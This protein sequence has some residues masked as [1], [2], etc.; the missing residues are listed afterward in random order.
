MNNETAVYESLKRMCIQ[1]FKDNGK[2][3]GVT[4]ENLSRSLNMQRTNVSR[5]LSKLVQAGKVRKNAARPVLYFVDKD[6][7]E[8]SKEADEKLSAFD[9]CIG[10]EGSLKNQIALAKAA[11]VYPPNGLHILILGET[12]VG[13][14]YFAKCIFKY[15]LQIGKVR[16]KGKFAVFNCAD[17]AN[18]PQLLISHLF[19]VK[20]GTY[21]G[22]TEDREGIIEKSRNGI[23]FLD[24]VHRLPPEGQEMLFTLM[25]EGKYVPFGGTKEIKID[26]MIISATTENIN[27][28]LLKTFTRRIPVTISLPPLREWSVNERIEL[29]ESFLNAESKR[30]SKKIKID[31]DAVTAIVNYRCPNNIGQLKSDIQIASAKAF[32]RSM[33]DNK[34]IKIKLE[35]F[36]NEVRNGLLI[37]KKIDPMELR[38]DIHGQN[39]NANEDLEDKYSISRNIYEFIDKRSEYL[40]R[41]GMDQEEIKNRLIND[42]EK[43]INDYIHNI[44]ED[45]TEDIKVIVNDELYNLLKSFMKLAEYKL[46]RNIPKNI[47]VGLLMHI[48]AFLT[49]I[50]ENRIIENPKIDEIK[51]KYPKEFK[52]AL[53]LAYKLEEKYNITIPIGE[54]GFITMFFAVD[55]KK[56]NSKVAIIVAMHGNSTASS[57]AEV[58][59]SL[60]NTNHVV[61]FD[62]PLY[63]K[64]EEAL[65]RIEELVKEKD[66]GKG[67]LILSDMGSLKYFGKIIKENTGIEVQ[68]I[69]MVSTAVVIEAA[70][71]A[72]LNDSLDEILKSVVI[73]SRYVGNS[74]EKSINKSR[75][76]II[77]ACF[78]G[79][80]TALK[81]KQLVYSKFNKNEYE[82]FNLSMK[83]KNEFKNTVLKMKNEYEIKYIISAFDPHVDDI[84]YIPM[85]IF[86]KEFSEEDIKDSA[87]DEQMINDMKD[88]YR[89]CLSLNNHDFIVNKFVSIINKMKDS[90]GL[91]L[92]REKLSGLLMHF[93]C[94]LEKLR[95]KEDICKCKSMK[96]ILSRYSDLFN[97]L[98]EGV[99]DIEKSLGVIIPDEGL[100]SIIEILVNI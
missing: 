64:P 37:S 2:V 43:F 8:F 75:K 74:L 25:D 15:T 69:D 9:V 29:I 45:D 36:S 63:M 14:S 94:L 71:K 68:T 73:E 85:E 13:K 54:I 31:E 97:M 44:R 60:L 83:D 35:D 47:F 33:F 99:V 86:F 39:S 5:E 89:D 46:N 32:L 50:K 72:M 7:V 42:V 77:T 19:G 95:D 38:L 10:K 92:D 34:D 23:L 70:R 41:K 59:N 4:T 53:L 26:V 30:V 48:D 24:E 62:M 55:G 82:V 67:T 61:G 93:G 91:H 28:V 58:S 87:S 49:R 51:K 52:I 12:G 27:S 3:K 76:V 80:G 57:M 40:K 1:Q 78:T 21:T 88:V 22:A 98:K 11:V 79:E 100:G 20:K 66:Q 56:V 6:N 17:Y 96:I 81:L 84:E 65:S 18:N 16:D 90:Y